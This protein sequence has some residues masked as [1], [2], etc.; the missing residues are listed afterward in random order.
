[1]KFDPADVRIEVTRGTGPGGQ[2]KNK[3]WSA[4][5]AIHEPTGIQVTIDG[6][7]QY[8]N[9]KKALSILRDRVN[10]HSAKQVAD[11]R[12]ERR[13]KLIRTRNI[14]RTYDY[15]SGRVKDHRTGKSATLDQVLTRGRIELLR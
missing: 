8:Q 14:I 15:K 1:M 6:R 12:K 10:E 7:K 3:T 5:R 13:D 2:H 4:I 11:R 9:K